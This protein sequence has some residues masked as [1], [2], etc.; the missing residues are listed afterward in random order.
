[1]LY[2]RFYI[3]YSINAH[4]WGYDNCNSICHNIC[5][6]LVYQVLSGGLGMKALHFVLYI[7]LLPILAIHMVVI[8][9]EELHEYT[10]TKRRVK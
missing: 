6:G 3:Y 1:M 7:L 8:A 5:G 9:A 2:W 4:S 10:T